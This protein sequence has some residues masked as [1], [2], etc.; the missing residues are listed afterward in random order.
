MEF[1]GHLTQFSTSL[2]VIKS[3]FIKFKKWFSSDFPL[4][5]K[6]LSLMRYEAKKTKGVM[7][8]H[9]E[10]KLVMLLGL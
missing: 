3:I 8:G 1:F 2:K 10:P 9:T 4:Y 5:N 7:E 6:R